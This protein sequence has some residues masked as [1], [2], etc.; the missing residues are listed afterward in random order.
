MTD[1]FNNV[2]TRG[3]KKTSIVVGVDL[4][5]SPNRNTGVCALRGMTATSI[6]TVHTDQEI[7]DFVERI[8]PELVAI[9]APLSLPPGRKIT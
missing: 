5:G 6:D 2:K 8:E 3:A 7:L 9:D 4:A 1:A